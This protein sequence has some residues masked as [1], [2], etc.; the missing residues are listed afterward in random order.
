METPFD[1]A[2]GRLAHGEMLKSYREIISCDGRLREWR[3]RSL[4]LAFSV[5][6]CLRGEW[7]LKR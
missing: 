1:Y 3:Q 5:T 6:P 4:R 2:Q 7:F